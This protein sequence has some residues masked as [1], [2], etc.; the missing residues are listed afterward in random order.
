MHCSSDWAGVLYVAQTVE[1]WQAYCLS[2]P[3]A[4]II[5]VSYCA[6]LGVCILKS[7]CHVFSS[8]LQKLL[9]LSG[10]H[11]Y[12]VLILSVSS[13]STYAVKA[14]VISNSAFFFSFLRDCSDFIIQ[15]TGFGNV[16]YIFNFQKLSR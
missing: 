9:E 11:L 13:S 3:N 12:L 6:G 8:L 15:T 1:L 5:D 2:L 4:E 10:S 7:R 14:S 16:F